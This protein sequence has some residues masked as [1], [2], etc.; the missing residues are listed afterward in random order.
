MRLNALVRRH[1]PGNQTL[2]LSTQTCLLSFVFFSPELQHMDFSILGEKAFIF[3][4]RFG[5]GVKVK[6]D[7]GSHVCISV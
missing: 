1:C 4:V 2:F 6:I 5:Q 7:K 3:R